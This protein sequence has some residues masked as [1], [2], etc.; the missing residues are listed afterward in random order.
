[1][2]HE[3]DHKAVDDGQEKPKGDERD[4]S[5]RITSNRRTIALTTP[6]SSAAAIQPPGRQNAHA[7]HGLLGQPLPDRRH[8]R[9]DE[10]PSHACSCPENSGTGRW[11]R[12]S[13]RTAD[14]SRADLGLA[15]INGDAPWRGGV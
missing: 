8:C 3:L 14:R 9:A 6:S 1:M 2:G 4:R 11:I 13:A 7:R 5:V 10:K 12:Q 15:D